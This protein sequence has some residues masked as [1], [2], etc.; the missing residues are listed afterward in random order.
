VVVVVMMMVVVVM[1][2]VSLPFCGE[3]QQGPVKLLN[4][5]LHVQH[6]ILLFILQGHHFDPPNQP[7]KRI[8]TIA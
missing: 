8:L 2:M 6:P 5:Y 1:M 3:M 7:F 4:Y